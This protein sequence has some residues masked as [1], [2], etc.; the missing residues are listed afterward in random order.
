MGRVHGPWASVSAHPKSLYANPHLAVGRLRGPLAALPSFG[1]SPYRPG[2]SGRRLDSPWGL[3]CELLDPFVVHVGDVDEA[4]VVDSEG[5][6]E[7]LGAGAAAEVELT[8]I[9]ARATPLRQVLPGGPV[10]HLDTAV[11]RVEDEDVT[12]ALATAGTGRLTTDW[13]NTPCSHGEQIPENA[14]RA[15]RHVRHSLTGK[16]RSAEAP[17]E[18]PPAA[19]LGPLFERAQKGQNRGRA[20]GDRPDRGAGRALLVARNPL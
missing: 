20:R 8:G 13:A 18:Y 11:P 2:N 10:E 12:G 9:A 6:G 1:I 16:V 7:V 19:E 4:S 3:R 17:L 15:P 14:R 5:S